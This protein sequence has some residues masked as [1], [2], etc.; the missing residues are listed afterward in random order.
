MLQLRWLVLLT[1]RL[2]L[3][4]G[5]R[6]ERA[7]H[8]HRGLDPPSVCVA[9]CL[10]RRCSALGR[11]GS[12]G[13]IDGFYA[14]TS[15]VGTPHDTTSTAFRT[16]SRPH[17]KKIAPQNGLVQDETARAA[18]PHRAISSTKCDFVAANLPK[19]SRASA[20]APNPLA[21]GSP[22]AA[23]TA[24]PH[25]TA[26]SQW[27]PVATPHYPGQLPCPH[28]HRHC[29]ARCAVAH[30][31]RWHCEM[32]LWTSARNQLPFIAHYAPIE[33]CCQWHHQKPPWRNRKK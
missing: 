25:L 6:H 12:V 30:K 27:Q 23:D 2:Q 7:P 33:T 3:P 9:E 13:R 29:K 17:Q 5:R 8:G 32:Q 18:E 4:S 19:K 31:A 11:G 15:L 21:F 26:P 16:S 10:C 24:V 14:S 1:T 22:P 28:R 20:R